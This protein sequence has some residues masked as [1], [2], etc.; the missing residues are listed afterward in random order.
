MVA[1]RALFTDTPVSSNVGNKIRKLE[2]R[3]AH[4]KPEMHTKTFG[5]AGSIADDA[6][7]NINLTNIA[8]GTATIERTGDRVR[9]WRVEM[10]GMCAPELDNYLFQ[11]KT[12]S[13]PTAAVFGTT[14]GA[15]LLD[16][17]TN[18][19]WVEWKHYRNLYGGSGI[20][21]APCKYTQSW[22]N[23]IIVRYNGSTSTAVVNNGLIHTILN[24]SG[25]AQGYN[26]SVRVWFTDA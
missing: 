18:S 5:L 2:R 24:R 26:I 15:F 3:S 20:D 14:A 6:V 21:N 16:S 23:G 9:V 8:R 1:K 13:E 22:K 17:E 7:V 12:T 19:R 4:N 10:R 11:Q 25:N